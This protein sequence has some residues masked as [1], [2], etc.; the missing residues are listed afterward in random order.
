VRR[1]VQLRGLGVDPTQRAE[2][3]KLIDAFLPKI[4]ELVE[5]SQGKVGGD[6]VHRKITGMGFYG[7]D[8]TTRGSVR[9]TV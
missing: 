1:Y 7:T 6:T 2:R 8:R 9:K 4:E 5:R 3:L